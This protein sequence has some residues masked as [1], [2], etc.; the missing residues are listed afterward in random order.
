MSWTGRK[1]KYLEECGFNAFEFGVHPDGRID[2]ST[3]DDEV[4]SGVTKEQGEQIA[5]Y[6]RRLEERVQQHIDLHYSDK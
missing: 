3:A 4:V 5:A 2:V 6:L 1:A